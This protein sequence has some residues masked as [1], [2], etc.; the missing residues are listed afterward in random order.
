MRESAMRTAVS[1]LI[2]AAALT[3]LTYA[4]DAANGNPARSAPIFLF[5]VWLVVVAVVRFLWGR[6]RRLGNAK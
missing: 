3:G 4:A 6:L 2:I 5:I 1:S